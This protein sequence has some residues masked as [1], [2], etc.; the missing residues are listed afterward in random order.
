MTDE[1]R[2]KYHMIKCM[3]NLLE[4]S[5][6]LK[7]VADREQPELSDEFEQLIAQI[8]NTVVLMDKS[9]NPIALVDDVI[10]KCCALDVK[11]RL[12]KMGVK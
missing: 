6:T 4:A 2:V 7:A 8:D 3:A 5:I 12:G 11:I 1:Q 10:A 9:E